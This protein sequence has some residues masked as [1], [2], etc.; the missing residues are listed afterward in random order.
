MGHVNKTHK[1]VVKNRDFIRKV[2]ALLKTGFLDWKKSFV[3]TH[4]I[5]KLID[6]K[7]RKTHNKQ[8][9][10][11]ECNLQPLTDCAHLVGR[12]EKMI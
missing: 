11:R 2:D 5:V 7:Y 10:R 12:K 9:D 3:L 8:A 4:S 1:S 6:S